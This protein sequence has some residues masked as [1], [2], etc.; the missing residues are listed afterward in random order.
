MFKNLKFSTIL[1]HPS[2]EKIIGPNDLFI[3]DIVKA[4]NGTLVTN[5]TKEF[6]K[7]I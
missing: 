3:A 6:K 5:N 7:G 4:N 1:M 2:K